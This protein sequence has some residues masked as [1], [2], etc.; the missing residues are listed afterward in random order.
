MDVSVDKT[1]FDMDK[2]ISIPSDSPDNNSDS[3]SDLNVLTDEPE[4]CCVMTKLLWSGD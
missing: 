3:D 1:G 4:N 2:I